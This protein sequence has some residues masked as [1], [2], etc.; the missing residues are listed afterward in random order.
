MK[1]FNYILLFCVLIFEIKAQDIHFS[2][3]NT[4]SSITNPASTAINKP[5]Q[6]YANYRNQWK[7]IAS[8]FVTY[9]FACDFAVNKTR[10]QKGNWAW[11]LSAFQDKL[12]EFQLRSFQSNLNIAY[13]INI[14][15]HS[16]FGAGVQG[17]FIQRSVNATQL[18]WGNQFDGLNYNSSLSSGESPLVSSISRFDG[19]IGLS[20]Y[21]EKGKHNQYANKEQYIEG[22][23]SIN[24][25]VKPAYSFLNT[26]ESLYMK[27][28]LFGKF[29]FK[30][31]ESALGIGPSFIYMR[32]G[33]MQNIMLG[34]MFSYIAQEAS[35]RTG[36]VKSTVISIGPYYRVKDALVI[37]AQLDHA[38]YSFGLSYDVNLS[39]FTKSTYSRGGI[40]L[41]FKYSTKSKLFNK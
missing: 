12:N 24:H 16:V 10:G 15:E 34:T 2:Q 27:S 6:T 9:S 11:G 32:Q 14:N 36:Y 20:Y 4:T 28:I 38:N 23:L 31:E 1:K 13:H 41:T 37:C 22:G 35:Q 30:P 5:F 17:S 40:E 26:S 39:S 19:G 33:P 21:S 18:K 8:P 7:S 29:Y 3:F 25:L